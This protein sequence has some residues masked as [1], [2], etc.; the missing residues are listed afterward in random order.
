MKRKLILTVG[1]PRSGKSTWAKQQGLPIVNAD[2]VR[3]ALHGE[4]FLGKAEPM[5]WTIIYIMT[6]ALFLAGHDT[7]ICDE[8]NITEK[9]RQ[10]WRDRFS[11]CEVELKVFETSPEECTRRAVA[12]NDT[13]ILP[14][15]E[16]MA[17][18]WDLP[19]PSA[20]SA[21]EHRE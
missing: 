10:A 7:I 21:R 4:R 19:I 16:R 5:V 15:I 2:S 11:D 6:E 14:V 12:L 13:I 20:W 18:E 17:S 9:R 3:L 1:L 8:T